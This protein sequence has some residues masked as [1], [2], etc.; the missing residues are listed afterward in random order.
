MSQQAEFQYRK[1][2]LLSQDLV[3]DKHV[4]YMT[5]D[6]LY[7]H[8]TNTPDFPVLKINPEKLV[9]LSQEDIGQAKE[10]TKIENTKQ[11]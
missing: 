7:P 4:M 5:N 9:T 8:P 11:R 1:Q 6:L 10:T 3:H 2:N